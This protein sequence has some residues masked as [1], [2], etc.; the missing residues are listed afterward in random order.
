MKEETKARSCQCPGAT[1]LCK[2]KTCGINLWKRKIPRSATVIPSEEERRVRWLSFRLKTVVLIFFSLHISCSKL[3]S[4]VQLFIGYHEKLCK[5][6]VMRTKLLLQVV[7]CAVW[8]GGKLGLAFYLVETAHLH[9]MPD[10][11][12]S[13][14]FGLLKRGG[15]GQTE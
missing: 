1:F 10:R 15:S 9:I 13:E 11:A 6:K 8:G 5:L 3:Q 2:G 14:D 7:M 4:L 12:E